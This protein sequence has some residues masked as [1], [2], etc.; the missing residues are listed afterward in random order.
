M[1]TTPVARGSLAGVL[2]VSA[3]A[4]NI[5]LL[6]AWT[7]L[8]IMASIL[9]GLLGA[10]HI[11]V[12]GPD[13]VPLTE[14]GD[15]LRQTVLL[16]FY[17]VSVALLVLRNRIDS[18][19]LAGLPLI[20]LLLWCVASIAWSVA[21]DPTLRRNIALLGTVTVGIYC[22]LRL[23]I[24]A[25]TGVLCAACAF[26]IVASWAHTAAFPTLGLDHQG[27]LRGMFA[28]KNDLGSFVGIGL[29][30]VVYKLAVE[31]PASSRIR[32]AFGALAAACAASIILSQ[33]ATPIGG[34]SAAMFVLAALLWASVSGGLVLAILPGL[35]GLSI[36]LMMLFAADF[37]AIVADVLGRDPTLSGRTTIWS[38]VLEKIGER[39]WLGYGFGVFWLGDQSPGAIFWYW[40]KQ[41]ELHTHNGYLQLVIDAGIIGAA[42]FGA[43]VIMLLGRLLVL[44]SG[45]AFHHVAWTA[46]FMAFFI[47]V[48]IT[49]AKLWQNNE[50]LTTM[51]VYAC[52]RTTLEYNRLTVQERSGAG[53]PGSSRYHRAKRY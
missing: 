16:L 42:L 7:A 24:R 3:D 51:L 46:A 37:S 17:G 21:P 41:F 23:D 10:Q 34:L 9:P 44:S 45:P 2:S 4:D 26:A 15:P 22:G 53:M 36:A 28:H 48:N 1:D 20:G 39:P 8:L 47:V 27:K 30:T 14:G 50:I 12:P 32:L 49:E 11:G 19:A 31:R 35:L 43:G 6:Y 5:D 13:E 38:F 40:S 18:L 29:M 25:W 33:S 52:T